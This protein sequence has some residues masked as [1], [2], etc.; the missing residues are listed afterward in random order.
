MTTVDDINEFWGWTGLIA[1]EVLAENDFGNLLIRDESDSVWWLCPQELRCR[2][3]AG[4][5]AAFD[6]LS[7][8]QHFLQRW[9]APDLMRVAQATLG[10]LASGRK[11]CMTVPA[12]LG[13]N[14]GPDNLATAPMGVLIRVS[15]EVAEAI[16]SA[17]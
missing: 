6:A 15:G 3:V 1:V 8:D 5:R 4:H 12:A 7:Y 2:Q 17:R 13:G 9:Y 10:P 14:C 11:Y 16:D